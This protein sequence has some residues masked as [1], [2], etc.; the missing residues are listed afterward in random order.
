ML[1]SSFARSSPSLFVEELSTLHL[2][3]RALHVVAEIGVANHLSDNGTPVKELAEKTDTDPVALRRLMQFLASYGIS[4]QTGPEAFCAT[5]LSDTLRDDHPKS[6]RP[7]I[8]RFGPPW[9]ESVGAMLEAVK[10]GEPSFPKIAGMHVFE[11]LSRNPEKQKRFDAGIAQIADA[12]NASVAAVYDFS[13][14]RRIVDVG[15]GQG[16]LLRHI[17]PRAPEATGILFDQP[18]VVS[19]PTRLEEAGLLSRCDCVGGDFFEAVPTGGDCYII[20]AV[21]HDFSDEESVRIL[22][23]CREAVS[24]GGRVLVAE[25]FLPSSSDG[26]HTNLIMDLLLMVLHTGH[27]RRDFEFQELFAEAG[28]RVTGFHK[29]QIRFHIVEGIPV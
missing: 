21:L 28:L 8:L 15:G 17:M 22:R 25:R 10:T 19:N 11:Y 29:T 12:D 27:E 16:G 13:R 1:V 18:Q 9:W 14:F 26:P 23:N 5:E 24:D 20:K 2:L 3:A 6:V 4:E 7:I